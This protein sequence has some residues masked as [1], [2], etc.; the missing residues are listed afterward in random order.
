MQ[1]RQWKELYTK[2]TKISLEVGDLSARAIAVCQDLTDHCSKVEYE[3]DTGGIDIDAL[4][5]SFENIEIALNTF[6]DTLPTDVPVDEEEEDEDD[7][8]LS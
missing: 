5:E 2:L 7:D 4:Q 8:D 1:Q 3:L 6:I